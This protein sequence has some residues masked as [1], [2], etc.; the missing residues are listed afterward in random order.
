MRAS[1]TIETLPV[2]S[3]VPS[4]D[5]MLADVILP[6]KVILFSF[7]SLLKVRELLSLFSPFIS[8]SSPNCIV[9]EPVG[10]HFSLILFIASCIVEK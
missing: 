10:L 6:L 2:R 4:V 5:I 1:L 8:S 9:N 3:M 7:Q